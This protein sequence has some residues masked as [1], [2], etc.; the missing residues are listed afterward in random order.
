VVLS[1]VAG[2]R[3]RLHVGQAV[4][5][6]IYSVGPILEG[7]GLNITAWS[8]GDDLNVSVLGCPASLPD[9]W[10]IAEALH[11]S[12]AE[13]TQASDRAAPSVPAEG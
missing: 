2:P 6:A 4:L 12:L 9:P 5:E 11:G 3:Q 7:I 1:N 8:Y 13:L 10:S